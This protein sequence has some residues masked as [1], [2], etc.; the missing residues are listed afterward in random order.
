[1][2]GSGNFPFFP[3]PSKWI[4]SRADVSIKAARKTA[5]EGLH[6]DQ[7]IGGGGRRGGEGMKKGFSEEEGG[8][9][10]GE[11]GENII[12]IMKGQRQQTRLHGSVPSM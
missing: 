9:R 5:L 2:R 12:I 6:C 8:G 11:E 3:S 4:Q 10:K 1:M 7:E